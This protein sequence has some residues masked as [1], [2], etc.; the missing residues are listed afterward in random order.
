M[1]RQTRVATVGLRADH[2]GVMLLM[3][4][5]QGIPRELYE[6]ADVDGA[7]T[8]RALISALRLLV[9]PGIATA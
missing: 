1:L 2:G 5:M 8:A 9:V 3:A 4:G 7:S 6:P